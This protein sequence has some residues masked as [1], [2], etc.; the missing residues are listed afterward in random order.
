MMPVPVL[1]RL[2][3][4]SAFFCG[5]GSARPALTPRRPALYRAMTFTFLPILPT[6]A[7]ANRTVQLY[8]G[9]GCRAPGVASHNALFDRGRAPSALVVA[10]VI[11]IFVLD[12][13]FFLHVTL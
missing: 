3:L 6:H 10:A 12:D 5:A 4:F 2:T 13:L 1:G 8:R 9:T 11:R 7:R